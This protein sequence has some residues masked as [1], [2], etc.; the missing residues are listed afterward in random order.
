MELL[1]VLHHKG[2]F[3][4]KQY[5]MK[6]SLKIFAILILSAIVIAFTE[7]VTITGK[8]KDESG[9]PIPGVYV[10]IKGTSKGT[11]TDQNG[12]YKITVEQKEASLVFSFIGYSTVT[13][14][15]SGRTVI[16]NNEG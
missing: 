9:N 13:E 7:S 5:V 15:V 11:V 3:N 4:Q 12:N 14:K 2:K 16:N 10:L 6:N 1:K 8:V